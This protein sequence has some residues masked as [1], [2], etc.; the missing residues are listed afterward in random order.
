[1]FAGHEASSFV[2]SASDS[3]SDA[4]SSAGAEPPQPTAAKATNEASEVR[5]RARSGRAK[6]ERNGTVLQWEQNPHQ[7]I[8]RYFS[9]LTAFFS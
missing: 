2:T 5:W 4:S 6:K 7:P 9:S 1:V 8:S 3:E